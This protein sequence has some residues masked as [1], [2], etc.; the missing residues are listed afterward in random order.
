MPPATEEGKKRLKALHEA[1][2]FP[3]P[4]HS[5]VGKEEKAMATPEKKEL[6]RQ[7]RVFWE[8]EGSS[9]K[10]QEEKRLEGMREL[11]RQKEFALQAEKRA[12]EEEKKAEEMRKEFALQAER[13]EKEKRK[14][15]DE[16][17]RLAAE[18]RLDDDWLKG[19][20]SD[21]Y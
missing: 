11:A 19:K 6:E 8:F 2:E 16:E 14:K 20:D 1:L 7:Q 3:K 17:E 4:T 18:K 13:K 21:V 15:E 9:I 5:G 10:R 12:E